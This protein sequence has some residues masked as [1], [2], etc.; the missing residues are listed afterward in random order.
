MPLFEELPEAIQR[1]WDGACDGALRHWLEN[2]FKDAAND[3]K[4]VEQ[5]A[6]WML[7]IGYDLGDEPIACVRSALVSFVIDCIA[8]DILDQKT[9]GL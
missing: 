5:K 2:D 9:I 6:A 3:R 1:A 8:P 7:K 4:R